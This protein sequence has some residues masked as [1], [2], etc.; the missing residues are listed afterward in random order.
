MATC[1]SQGTRV[2]RE[3]TASAPGAR[4]PL[5]SG[6]ICRSLE[7]FPPQGRLRPLARTLPGKQREQDA[8]TPRVQSHGHNICALEELRPALFKATE[9]RRRVERLSCRL[10]FSSKKGVDAPR[11]SRR[12]LSK[13]PCSCGR[14]ASPV[15]PRPSVGR[16]LVFVVA[17]FSFPF[18][19]FF[20]TRD[21]RRG[22]S[23]QLPRM[24][25][26]RREAKERPARH[27]FV[28]RGSLIE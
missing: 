5:D 9:R 18:F 7:L 21:R 16:A 22:L 2:C 6:A 28:A 1:T 25:A 24:P 12:A 10:L 15:I 19:F 3:R 13:P 23:Q 17:H 14:R 27:A 20:D 8:T 26:G 11:D 4:S